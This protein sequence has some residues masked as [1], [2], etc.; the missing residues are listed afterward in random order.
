MSLQKNIFSDRA[1]PRVIQ[2]TFARNWIIPVVTVPVLLVALLWSVDLGQKLLVIIPLSYAAWTLG[3]ACLTHR[4]HKRDYEAA[5]ITHP[6]AA[7]RN[8]R[9]FKRALGVYAVIG[10]LIFAFLWVRLPVGADAC[11]V[12]IIKA[13]AWALVWPVFWIVYL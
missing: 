7:A 11:G 13:V 4:Q 9:H 1:T 10:I 8:L 5:R 3:V 12:S 6:P 2:T